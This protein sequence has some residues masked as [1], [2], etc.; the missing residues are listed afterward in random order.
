MTVKLPIL[1]VARGSPR[2]DAKAR[3]RRA[4]G[5]QIF[6][7]ICATCHG[8]NGQADRGDGRAAQR[9][10]SDRAELRGARDA[11]ARREAGPQGLEEQADA[12]V[13]GRAHATRR[14][15]RSRPTS[16]RRE[17]ARALSEL[18]L[19]AHD[20]IVVACAASAARHR[21]RAGRAPTPRARGRAR[22][23]ARAAR[24]ARG[25]PSGEPVLPSA[26]AT[27]RSS[28]VARHAAQRRALHELAQLVRAL[29]RRARRDRAARA[30]RE[31]G[32][33][34]RISARLAGAGVERAD[35]LADVAAE[36]PRAD[37]RAQLARDRRRGARSSGTRCS[38]ARRARTRRRTR[39]VGHASRHARQL[40][41]RGFGGS[42]GRGR[43]RARRRRAARRARRSCRGRARS[44]S[45]SSRRSRARRARPTR[46]RA[47]ARSRRTAAS[48]PARPS[49]RAI[50]SAS[51]T[52]WSRITR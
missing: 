45:C 44:A 49:S 36:H 12:G 32:A 3:R 22:R 34:Q 39:C 29:A 6:G 10:R 23:D 17:F 33:Q 7:S 9:P 20:R 11:A 26:T 52:S 18:E 46:A 41:Q 38:A 37:R 50:R 1:L 25:S 14:S 21:R 19:G 42:T 13:R 40:P 30:R 2:C 27:L 48:R 35:L 16:R 47:P 28:T 15:R 8:P 24:R 4:D 51:A 5:A 31:R 43:R